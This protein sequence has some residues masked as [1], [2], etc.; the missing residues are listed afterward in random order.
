MAQLL[1]VQRLAQDARL[2]EQRAMGLRSRL[3][4]AERDLHEV[5]ALQADVERQLAAYGR[6]CEGREAVGVVAKL[7]PLRDVIVYRFKF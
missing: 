1:D 4:V 7:E 3:T 2:C 5:W 6:A